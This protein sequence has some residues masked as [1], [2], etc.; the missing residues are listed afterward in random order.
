M[1]PYRIL[2]VEDNPGDLRLIKEA[3]RYYGIGFELAHYNTA[4]T[5]ISA[6]DRCGREGEGI[7]HL[8]LLD[9]NV[10]RGDGRDILLAAAQNPCLNSVPKA[11][12]TS[13]ISEED[14]NQARDLGARCFITKPSDLDGFLTKVGSTIAGLLNIPVTK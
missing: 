5:A 1:E 9:Y 2:I 12:L 14:R 10:P 13:S 3:L 7:P 8:I 11:V 6:L 4:D